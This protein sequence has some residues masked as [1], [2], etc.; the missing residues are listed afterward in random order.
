MPR[1]VHR[2]PAYRHHKSTQQAVV[3]FLGKKIYL[4]PY[5]SP[6]SH[7]RYQEL[8]KKWERVR[9]RE[10]DRSFGE[11]LPGQTPGKPSVPS[12]TAAKLREKRLCGSPITIN[13]VI[14]VYRQH[15]Q[16]YYQ[17]NGEISVSG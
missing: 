10:E 6:H 16:S 17:K 9:F 11:A 8:L 15:T 3:S 5:S 1:L 7:A 14:F 4:G 2:P 13:E 12:I